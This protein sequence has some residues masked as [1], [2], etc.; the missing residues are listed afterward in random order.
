MFHNSFDSILFSGSHK[1]VRLSGV[2][3]GN[4]IPLSSSSVFHPAL[5]PACCL[6]MGYVIAN[7]FIVIE[8]LMQ[9]KINHQ[10]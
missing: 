8:C 10:T 6:L 1:I 9:N 7:W 3:F 2:S 4:Q 5:Q